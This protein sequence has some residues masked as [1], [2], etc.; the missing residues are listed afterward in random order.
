M[1]TATTTK[2]SSNAGFSAP[3]SAA[4]STLRRAATR[5]DQL[6]PRTRTLL[7]I[8]TAALLAGLL[9]AY[10][11]LPA[12]RGRVLNAE[13]IPVLEAKLATMRAQYEE[14][15]R[16]N[17]V[18]PAPASVSASA[19][20]S[21]SASASASATIANSAAA[22]APAELGALQ[23]IFGGSAKITIDET[24]AFR[25]VIASTSYVAFLDKLD[26]ALPRYRLKV[27]TLN[28]VALNTDIGTSVTDA[29]K[30]EPRLVS[31]EITLA[32]DAAN[33]TNGALKQ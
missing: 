14:M 25:V 5:W 20:A 22:R 10:A 1:N 19:P 18:P 11:W 28:I 26:Q 8:A 27:A 32:D 23:T 13:R 31:V 33:A 4:R 21:A 16:I 29:K 7:L 15:K 2:K 12:V 24:R 30:V 9:Y 17:A 3:G 6:E